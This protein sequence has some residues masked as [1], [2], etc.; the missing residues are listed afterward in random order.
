[1]PFGKFRLL[2]GGGGHWEGGVKK[3]LLQAPSDKKSYSFRLYEVLHKIQD[4]AKFKKYCLYS[5]PINGYLK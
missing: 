1:M 3:A 2:V 4:G 5:F